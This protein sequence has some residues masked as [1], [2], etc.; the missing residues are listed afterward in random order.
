MKKIVH[1]VGY[2]QITWHVYYDDVGAS[3]MVSEA[4]GQDSTKL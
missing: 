2:L 3:N 4:K 1:Q